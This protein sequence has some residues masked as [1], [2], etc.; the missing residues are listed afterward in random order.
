MMASVELTGR[1]AAASGVLMF[2]GVEGEWLLDPQRDDGTVSN[3]PVF[4][5]LTLTATVGFVLLLV[6]AM[7][8]RTHT[9]T[10]DT[11][12]CSRWPGQGCWAPSAWRP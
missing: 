5:L 9:A 7:G 3:L 2:V 4:A 10:R 11:G 8:L 12:G 1:A 6:A